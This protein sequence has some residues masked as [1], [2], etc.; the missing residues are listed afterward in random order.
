M[1][2]YYRK[3][4]DDGTIAELHD[5]LRDKVRQQTPHADGTSRSDS[6]TVCIMDSQSAK[7]TEEGTEG[8]GYDA[9]KTVKG[10]KRHIVVDALGLVLVL[11]VTSASVQD[12]DAAVPIAQE[13]K[14]N[15]PSLEVVFL[16]GA[17]RGE[18]K[19][20]IEQTTQMRVEITLRS[21]TPKKGSSLSLLGGSLNEHLGG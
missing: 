7:T 18:A 6:P 5:A 1:F 11:H 10:R 17:Y 19:S 13:A 14:Q 2:E 4:R 8:R 20:Q 16:D 12:R 15:F 21:D 3:W 9:G